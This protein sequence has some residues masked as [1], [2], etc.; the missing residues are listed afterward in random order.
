MIKTAKT[1]T[2]APA[3][4]IS[5]TT[6]QLFRAVSIPSN[7]NIFNRFILQMVYIILNRKPS[8]LFLIDEKKLLI[9]KK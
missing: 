3:L 6:V 4:N 2:K 5:A 8:H 1:P 9:N 7:N